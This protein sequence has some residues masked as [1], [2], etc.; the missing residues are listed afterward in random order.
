MK[1]SA[2]KRKYRTT[3]FS[4]ALF[5]RRAA[6]AATVGALLA[7]GMH[8]TQAAT[9]YT[10]TG[11]TT[12]FSTSISPAISGA[13]T[14]TDTLTFTGGP[15]SQTDDITTALNFNSLSFNN[16]D[17]VTLNPGAGTT[18]SLGGTTPTFNLNNTGTLNYNLS[19]ALTANTS[20]TGAGSAILGGNT[21]SSGGNLLMNGTGTVTLG[22]AIDD[23]GL[24]AVVSSG[25]LVLGKTSN[26]STH[27]I[28]GAG[29]AI[30]S[31][32]T[33]QLAG[34]G[35]DQ[36]YDNDT[37][38]LNSGGTF[39]M[40]GQNETVNNFNLKGT[41]VG[42]NGA[43]INNSATSSTLTSNINFGSG[44][45]F[46]VGGSG[47]LT[48]G[49]I[50]NGS[51]TNI[52]TKIG[53]GTVTLGGTVDNNALAAVV[54]SG[55]LVLNKGAGGA[56]AVG[57]GLTINGG[58][59]QLG[60][61]G[62]D[63]IFDGTFVAVNSGTFDLNGQSEGIS[64]LNGTGG[65]VL[66]NGSALSTLTIG[67]SSGSGNYSGVIAD[68]N[69]AGTGT[70]ALT[71][72]GSGFA[73][74]SGANTYSGAT[75]INGGTL[76]F[77]K[78]QALST[79]SVTVANGGTLALGVGGAGD[80]SNATSGAGSIGGVLGSATF[81]AGSA[82][83][84]DT[85]DGSITYAGDIGSGQAAKGLTKLGANTL[86][87]TATNTYTGAT[88]VSAGT[89]QAGSAQ[90]FGFSSQVTLANTA[91]A[92]LDLNGNNTTIGSLAG[93]G[94]AGGNVS[95]GASTLTLGGNNIGTTYS[96]VLSGVGG[97]L[98]KIGTAQ[99]T[100]AGTNTFTG[101]MTVNGGIV[102]LNSD[103]A[104]GA[105]PGAPTVNITLNGGELVN[106]T[107]ALALNANRTVS[108]G[109]GGGSFRGANGQ[110][111][112]I[113]GQ[114]TGVG[115][116]GIVYDGA[117][118]ILANAANNY[119]G[120]TTI[121]GT[122]NGSY[123]NTALLQAGV[124]N[125]LPYGAGTGNVVF[126]TDTAGT[127]T[128]DLHG[129]STQIN[130]LSS[131]AGTGAANAIVTNSSGTGTYTLTLGNNNATGTFN[132]IIKST[133]GTLALTK[134][135]AGQETLTGAN[136][137]TGTT[138]VSGGTLT[139]VNNHSGGSNF[140]DNGTLE[141]NV[142][143][144]TQALGTGTISGSGILLKSGAGTLTMGGNGVVETVAMTGGVI[145]VEG[146]TLRN[147]YGNGV[148]TNNKAS[149]NVASGTT[150]D[151]WDSAGGITV[152]ALT[153]S[154]TV[155]HSNYG[156]N[157]ENFTVGS[158]NGTG[159]FSGT[160]TDVSGGGGGGS[161]PLALV[162][163][164]TGTQTLTGTNTYTS[165]TTINGGTLQVGNG[166]A[167]GTLPTGSVITDNA[168][169]TINRSNAVTQGTDFSGSAIGGSGSLT[170]AGAGTT[171]LT[172]AN[173][174][175]GATTITAGTLQVGNGSTGSIAATSGISV[176]GGAALVTDNNAALSN[177]SAPLSL[178][179]TNG[180]AT[181]QNGLAGATATTNVQQAGALALGVGTEDIL[182]FGSNSGTFDFASAAAP[183]ASNGFGLDS[184]TG[185]SIQ[186]FGAAANEQSVGGSYQ[187]LFDN[188]L[189]PQQ[190]ADISFL[191]GD[192]SQFGASEVATG[193]GTQVQ[194]VE[195]T[196]PAPEPAQAA[197]LG[198][199]GLGLGALI[200]KARKR[201]QAAAE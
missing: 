71:K 100:L 49:T 79:G 137:Y 109:S 27:A 4:A 150:V 126:A 20:F 104:A 44:N 63:Q 8:S 108:L 161:H 42:G 146:G 1:R 15:Y 21:A 134:T 83:G 196:S 56:H 200:F 117:P 76:E 132:G 47:N 148:W 16:T 48:L 39:D 110:S 69:N 45:A 172:A 127:E 70:L 187:L 88:T 169:L 65:I 85:T 54:T 171:T 129:F 74:L 73:T 96:G 122:F 128:L 86:T 75:A 195:S 12:L 19:L 3:L 23:N 62:G 197:A 179:D 194:I 151:L 168:N 2:P 176:S 139:F 105:V 67:T 159:S 175:N 111:F 18:I 87:L 29:L 92:V 136:T 158:N 24:G 162:K 94:A 125:A 61:A 142:T 90:A 106:S 33:V 133:S 7:V 155:Q 99:L 124:T 116:L 102:Q 28:G 119:A 164:G 32:G 174:Y 141:F 98:I 35:G 190:L 181:L 183:S 36:I 178:G 93:G 113:N 144:G 97:S 131:T 121:G 50:G 66:D 30:N 186:G 173:T 40:N 191:N 17:V 22:G 14:N 188:P 165:T 13:T 185:L 120:N 91:G 189:T 77:A 180:D 140:V 145:D 118:I 112:T 46:S 114:I 149:L 82:L 123:Q 37:V 34:S 157:A 184:G 11:S 163:T 72:T 64:S 177:S 199:F 95:L 192:S 156:N 107:S 153:G 59:A 154:G 53:T 26:G 81:A 9:A 38:Y 80:F 68:N 147:D 58:T 89:L 10:D 43:L 135:G 138:T 60:S 115:G 5:N 57:G 167:S 166:G 152:D 130:G 31:G 201:G 78:T 103:A 41:G 52:L 51:G 193:V 182:S 25:T 143:A 101:G 170:Q 55:T 198:V 84:I 160:I 6:Q